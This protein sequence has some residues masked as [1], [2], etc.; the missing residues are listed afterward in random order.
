MDVIEDTDATY[1]AN[2]GYVIGNE[3]LWAIM[4]SNF[5]EAV[6]IYAFIS[7]ILVASVLR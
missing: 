7:P 5:G 3:L 2:L 6:F 4:G 1:E